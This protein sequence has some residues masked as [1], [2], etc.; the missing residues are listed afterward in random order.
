MFGRLLFRNTQQ[1]FLRQKTPLQNLTQSPLHRGCLLNQRIFYRR[2]VVLGSQGQESY[3]EPPALSPDADK[4]PGT[5]ECIP[6]F[7]KGWTA[8]KERSLWAL[9][10]SHE[11]NLLSWSR[12]GFLSTTA[13]AGIY[14]NDAELAGLFLMIC[15]GIF[16]AI[17]TGQYLYAARKASSLGY[18]WSWRLFQASH[19]LSVCFLWFIG[20]TYF[21]GFT[22]EPFRSHFHDFERWLQYMRKDYGPPKRDEDEI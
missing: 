20:I 15:S 9:R 18:P 19:S 8:E 1:V 21:L 2:K 6:G 4:L 13:G 14:A 16:I 3:T 11:N 17:G 22:P 12:N 10:L 7:E 5:K